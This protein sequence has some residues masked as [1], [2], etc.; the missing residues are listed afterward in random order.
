MIGVRKP[1]QNL[2]IGDVIEIGY[3]ISCHCEQR[4]EQQ[5]NRWYRAKVIECDVDTW[6]LARLVDGQLTE[7]RPFMIWRRVPSFEERQQAA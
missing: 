3:R 6:P 2:E 7:I 5:I 1:L 4:E